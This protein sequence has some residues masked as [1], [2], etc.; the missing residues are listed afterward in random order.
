MG[1]R[2]TRLLGYVREFKSKP[3]KAGPS[4]YTPPKYRL[5]F[6]ERVRRQI[7]ERQRAKKVSVWGT[8][9]GENRRVQL[10]GSGRSLYH[11]LLDAA[12]HPPKKRFLTVDAENVR[13]FLDYDETWDRHPDVESH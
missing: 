12:K 2:R 11:A 7:S 6:E 4:K 3:P 1:M 5:T 13:G 10:T 8:V 9:N